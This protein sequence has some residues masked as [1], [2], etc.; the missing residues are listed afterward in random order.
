MA[1]LLSESRESGQGSQ[2]VALRSGGEATPLF[3]FHFLDSSQR[4]ASHLGDTRPVYF[5]ASALERERRSHDQT[6]RATVTMEELAASC[7]ADVRRVQ[8]QGPYVL[9]GLC[10]GGV[11]AFEVANQLTAQWQEV[12][13]LG[14]LDSFYSAG[15]I[16]TSMPLL[17]RW[18]YHAKQLLRRGP[19]YVPDKIRNRRRYNEEKQRE[20]R[21]PETDEARIRRFMKEIQRGYGGKTYSGETMLVRA[22]MSPPSSFEV[23]FGSLNGWEKVLLGRVHV[24]DVQCE[25]LELGVEPHVV[26]QAAQ[27]LEKHLR[28][29][30][31]RA[32]GS[33]LQ[34]A[35]SQ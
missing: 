32:V 13:F 11:L 35:G 31:E 21:Q 15:A 27:L 24:E 4:I 28:L 7:L 12:K 29:V 9:A 26:A 23:E 17:R 8:P 18:T 5:I 33:E 6:G 25:H 19:G 3:L 30:D 2:V 34:T 14:L 10:F 20:L 22:A 16:R 1:E